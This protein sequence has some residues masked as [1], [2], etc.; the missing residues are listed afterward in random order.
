VNDGMRPPASAAAASGAISYLY[1]HN[2]SNHTAAEEENDQGT[3]K[4][5]SGERNVNSGLQ[6]QLKKDGGGSTRQSLVETRLVCGVCSTG[7]VNA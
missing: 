7:R 1:Q 5:K 3:P 4:K 2:N 6:V